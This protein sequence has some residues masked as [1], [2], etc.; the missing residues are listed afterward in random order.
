L[1]V[2]VGLHNTDF[3]ENYNSAS[4]DF[5]FADNFNFLGCFI[6]WDLNLTVDQFT[7]IKVNTISFDLNFFYHL[8]LF[9]SFWFLLLN[10]IFVFALLLLFIS[11]H[12][13]LIFFLLAL[14][15]LF[16]LLTFNHQ[17][18]SSLVQYKIFKINLWNCLDQI[19]LA[20]PKKTI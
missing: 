17:L 18:I 10:L 13:L 2:S 14:L 19:S 15:V 8:L 9:V 4:K 12:L 5:Y 16:E 3:M 1:I 6:A 11:Y 7:K 20:C